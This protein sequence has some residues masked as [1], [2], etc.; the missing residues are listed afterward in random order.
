MKKLI[1]RLLIFLIGIPFFIFIIYYLPYYH[2]LCF[3]IVVIIFSSLGAVEF[4]IMLEKKGLKISKT[5]SAILGALPPLAM[6][7]IICFQNIPFIQLLIPVIIGGTLSWLFVS[8]I[9][10][11]GD[12]LNNFVNKFAAGLS[13]LL[14]PGILMLWIVRMCQWENNS[15]FIIVFLCIIFACDSTAWAAGI[16]FGKNNSGIVAVSPNK[17][18]AGFI[19]G[20]IG[21]II[22]G[23]AAV[24]IFS[25]I[26]IPV[27]QFYGSHYLSGAFMGLFTGIA[28]VLGDLGES[29][30][31][32][33]CGIKDSGGI[34]PGRGGVLD[35]IDSISLAA[36]GFYLIFSLL[37]DQTMKI[38]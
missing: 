14:Y 32:R 35:S 13:V 10:S 8:R 27:Y 26:F 2:N 21:S 6:Y 24:I 23:L 37:F 4:S 17:S 9:F 33:S 38:P 20:F 29:G 19:G 18:I 36:P 12:S 34:I 15:I 11:R 25:D 3:N 31:K 7:L 30:I 1:Q 5:E 28:A 16:L 22:V